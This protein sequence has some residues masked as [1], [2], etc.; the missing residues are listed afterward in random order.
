MQFSIFNFQSVLYHEKVLKLKH[1]SPDSVGHT[2]TYDYALLWIHTET[3]E[4]L[5]KWS[6]NQHTDFWEMFW[7]FANII[8]SHPYD[9]VPDFSIISFVVPSC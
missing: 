8:H 7:K 2:I 1:R 3:Y 4:E 5:H 9:E 6:V